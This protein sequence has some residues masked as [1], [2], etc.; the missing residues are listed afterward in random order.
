MIEGGELPAF[1]RVALLALRSQ[2]PGVN[3]TGAMT[4]RAIGRELLGGDDRGMTDMTADVLVLAG[5][6]PVAVLRVVEAG[7]LPLVIAVTMLA[8]RSEAAGMGVLPLVAAEAVLRNLLLQV[9]AAMAV[10][11]V[12]IRMG[13][14]EG[15][16]RL[17]LMIELCSLPAGR[18]MAASA[19]AAALASMHVIRR[20]AGDAVLG[21]ALVAIPE[22][23]AL[24]G[25]V[26]VLVVERE[27]RL[28]MIVAGLPPGRCVVARAAIAPELAVVGLFFLVAVGTFRGSFAIRLARD[29]TA[30]AGHARMRLSQGKVRPL[31]IELRLA[32]LHDVG[33]AAEMLRVAGAALRGADALDVTV[34]AAMP[35]DIRRDVLVAIEAEVGLAIAVAAIVARRALLFVLRVRARELPRH[36]ERFGIHRFTPANR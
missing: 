9:A 2:L 3:I 1:G 7:G 18:R 25:D 29:V 33:R 12:E 32:E 28:V 6:L 21:S 34:I 36:E 15:E 11:T 22:V 14:F 8:L 23:A 26:L 27:G 10:L 20:V 30:R 4:A 5:Q 17:L 13:A 31:M 24:A 19:L 35:G 16:A